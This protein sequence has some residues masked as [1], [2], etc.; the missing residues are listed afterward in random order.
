MS[1]DTGSFTKQWKEALDPSVNGAAV[2]A[3]A[4]LGEPLDDIGIAQAVADIPA[5]RQ[6]NHVVR[7]AM[8]RKGTD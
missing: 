2:H 6:S 3:Q 5:D 1:M 4:S 8:M 7:K